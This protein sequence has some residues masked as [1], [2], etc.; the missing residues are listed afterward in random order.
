VNGGGALKKYAGIASVFSL[1]INIFI[2]FVLA[3]YVDFIGN[4]IYLITILLFIL[5]IILAFLSEKG[6]WKKVAFGA[7]AAIIV[8]FLLFYGLM[9]I[10][11]S[12]P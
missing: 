11:W 7:I 1:V 9:A 12:Q 8:I 10:L 6:L 2:F 3:P 4:H 5:S